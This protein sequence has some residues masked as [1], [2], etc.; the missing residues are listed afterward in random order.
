MRKWLWLL[1]MALI[2]AIA[3]PYP[4]FAVKI[5]VDAGHGGTDSGA[6]GVNGLQEKEVNLDIAERVRTELLRR[7]YEVA[8]TRDTDQY[9]SLA[10]RV[11]FANGQAADL[12]V[13]IH[14]N[15]Y[16]RATAQ[17]T[18]VLYYDDAYPQASYP[19]SDTMKALSPVSRSFAQQMLDSFLARSGTANDGIVPSAVYVVRMGQMPSILVETAFLSNAAEAGLL[20]DPNMR[21]TMALGIADGIEAFR[22][23]I[24]PDLGQHWAREAVMRLYAKG[25]VQ[26]EYNLFHPSRALT[27]AELVTL[28][29]RVF[30]QAAPQPCAPGGAP[31]N[32]GTTVYGA[33][34]G[35]GGGSGCAAATVST[36]ADLK[37]SHWA[38][39]AMRQ[40]VAAGLLEGYPDGTI[41]LD[42]PVT[43]EE[44]AVLLDRMMQRAASG[45]AGSFSDA[46]A[47][48]SLPFRDV[49]AG[50]W[51]AAAIGRLAAAGIVTGAADGLFVPQ[52]LITR[53]EISVMLDRYLSR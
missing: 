10:D 36:F 40:A 25:L 48:G 12:F 45:G 53:A 26:G 13:S 18:M 16:S 7:G 11:A 1:S 19:A 6:I 14:A 33:V 21:S 39:E 31:A 22:P 27:R 4:A 2:C 35:D 20:A 3:I 41:R 44:T 29:E 30:P 47:S 46:A 5:V 51:S 24:F 34:Y 9:V 50:S 42:R 15:S 23:P 32:V 43:R 37:P 38:Y 28:L 17:G 49:A 52:R 8:M